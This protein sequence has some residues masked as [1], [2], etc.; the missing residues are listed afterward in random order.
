MCMCVCSRFMSYPS[1]KSCTDRRAA[2][3]DDVYRGREKNVYQQ[4]FPSVVPI[5]ILFEAVFYVIL[6]RLYVHYVLDEYKNMH[7]GKSHIKNVPAAF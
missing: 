1:F 4:I 3:Y 5:P 7:G 6:I 2:L